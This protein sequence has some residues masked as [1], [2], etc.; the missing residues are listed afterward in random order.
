MV[1]KDYRS[2]I[3]V[4][5]TVLPDTKLILK[6]YLELKD[7]ELLRKEVL[8]NNLILKTSKRRAETTRFNG[9]TLHGVSANFLL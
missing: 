3:K 1:S 5:G 8:D 2:S 6:K 4:V 9:C 7:V